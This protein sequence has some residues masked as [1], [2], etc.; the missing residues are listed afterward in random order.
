M[1]PTDI[2]DQVVSLLTA[3]LSAGVRVAQGVATKVLGDKVSQRL[4]L[5]KQGSKAWK[6]FRANPQ[7]DSLIR[8]FLSQEL[9]NDGGFRLDLEKALQDARREAAAPAIYQTMNSSGSGNIQVGDAAGNV[10]TNGSTINANTTQNAITNKNKNKKSSGGTVTGFIAIIAILVAMA[11]VGVKVVGSFTKSTNS[12]PLEQPLATTPG[13][14]TPSSEEFSTPVQDDTAPSSVNTGGLSAPSDVTMKSEGDDTTVSATFQ[15]SKILKASAAQSQWQDIT[16]DP[17]PCANVDTTR[18]AV[19]VGTVS[20]QNET[21]S[22]TPQ[23]RLMFLDPLN[24]ANFSLDVG[25]DYSNQPGCID[26]AGGI[27]PVFSQGSSWGP[28]PVE[29]ILHNFYSPQEP[30]GQKSAGVEFNAIVSENEGYTADLSSDSSLIKIAPDQMQH[31][32]VF[33]FSQ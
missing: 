22:F 33:E 4:S 9:E 24:Y 13:S 21:P 7:N 27:T 20:F 23:V 12:N 28:V 17:M 32:G 29:I 2:A 14:V 31:V 8:Y 25:V 11:F 1:Q 19:V 16:S 10:A 30:G 5:S 15:F 26:L 6:E 3:T 18:D